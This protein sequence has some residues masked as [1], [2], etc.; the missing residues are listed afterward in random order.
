MPLSPGW[1]KNEGNVNYRVKQVRKR[2]FCTE[3]HLTSWLFLGFVLFFGCHNY[4]L[5]V[6]HHF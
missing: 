4:A 3:L 1:G 5:S 6:V 2:S